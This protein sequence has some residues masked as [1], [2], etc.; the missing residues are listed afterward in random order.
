MRGDKGCSDIRF[1]WRSRTDTVHHE[2]RGRPCPALTVGP[3]SLTDVQ[4]T[5]LLRP[6]SPEVLVGSERTAVTDHVPE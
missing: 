3:H 2:A 5:V 1:L 4:G 6:S